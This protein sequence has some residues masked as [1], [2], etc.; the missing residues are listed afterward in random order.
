[1]PFSM[2]INN[3][4]KCGVYPD[5]WKT[6]EVVLLEKSNFVES[7][8]DFRPISLLWHLGKL[9][10]KAIMFFFCVTIL[11]TI[12]DNQFAYQKGKSTTDALITAIDLWT[13]VLD[14]KPNNSITAAFLDMS[15]AFDGIDKGKLVSI[16]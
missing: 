10:E 3:C 6:A 15:K 4:F 12:K 1:M 5:I 7:V 8:S 13:K 16:C 11:P 14:E 9:M 2:I